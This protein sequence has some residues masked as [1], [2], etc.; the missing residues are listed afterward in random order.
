MLVVLVMR[1]QEISQRVMFVCPIICQCIT[2]QKINLNILE[3]TR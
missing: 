2:G 3:K 1:T